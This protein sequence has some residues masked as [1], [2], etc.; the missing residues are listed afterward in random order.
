MSYIIVRGVGMM[1]RAR[2]EQDF[3]ALSLP[4]PPRTSFG[5]PQTCV[6][7]T[8]NEARR[9]LATSKINFLLLLLVVVVV[10]V[11]FYYY[12]CCRYCCF[13]WKHHQS[14]SHI[15]ADGQSASPSWCRAPFGTHDQML[16]LRS[17]RYSVSRPV[18]SS[19][20]K[21]RVCHLS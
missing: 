4:L 13:E 21:G 20:T 17:D 9:Y 3:F 1:D 16:S 15:S 11:V 19:L 7:V 12:W 6:F 5:W 18:A 8:V 14:Q 2:G 10:A